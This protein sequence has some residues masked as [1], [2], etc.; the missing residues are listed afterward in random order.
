VPP[1]GFVSAFLSYFFVVGLSLSSRN[2]YYLA[3]FGFTSSFGFFWIWETCV[4]RPIG[5][6]VTSFES[7]SKSFLSPN[8]ELPFGYSGFFLGGSGCFLI[9]IMGLGGGETLGGAGGA[10]LLLISTILGS[11]MMGSLAGLILL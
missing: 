10:S 2:I 11:C 5:A 4:R 6:K 1:T 3:S 9:S 8:K 7:D